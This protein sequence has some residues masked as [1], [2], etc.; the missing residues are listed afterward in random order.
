M[1][2]FAAPFQV[3]LRSLIACVILAGCESNPGGGTVSV[4]MYYGVGFYDPWYY[5]GAYYPPDVIVTPP[6]EQPDVGPRPEHPIVN[7][8][9]PARLVRAR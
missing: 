4:G 1:K 7:P 2:T 5:G 8:L 3:V 9:G 6:P